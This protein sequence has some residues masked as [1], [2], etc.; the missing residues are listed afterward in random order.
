MEG[1]REQATSLAE[2][3]RA[4]NSIDQGTQKNAAM[5]EESTAASHNLAR[6]AEALF[7][8]LAQ[9]RTGDAAQARMPAANTSRSPASSPA[10]QLVRKVA[11]AFPGGNA[12]TTHDDWEEF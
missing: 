12:A 4:V 8:L 1:A 2:V 3:N 5:V 9:F 7:S 11:N 10:R 6:D